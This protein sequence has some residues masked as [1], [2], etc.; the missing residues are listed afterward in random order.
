MSTANACPERTC[1]Q[2]LLAGQLGEADQEETIRHVEACAACQ[3]V[4]DS[5]TPASQS[6][7]DVALQLQ[8]ENPAPAPELR[9]VIEQAK[10]S[11]STGKAAGREDPDKTEAQEQ[12]TPHG[13]VSSG[14]ETQAEQRSAS[15]DDDLAF[16]GPSTKPDAIGRLGHYEILEVIGKGGFGVVLKGF[17]EK[18]HRIVAIKVLSPAYA[19]NGAARKRFIREAQTAA[20]VKNEHVVAIYSVQDEAQPPYL[21]MELI[22]GISLQDKLDKKGPLSLREILRIGLQTAEGLAAA[23]KQ[24]LVHRDIKP[25]NILLENGVERVKITD[26]GLARAVDDA[27]VTQSGTVAGTPM[28]MSPEQA[29]AMPIDHRSDLFSLGTVLYSICTGHPPF[30]ASGTHAVL[31]RVI[32]ASPRPIRELNP[33]IPDWLEAII[34]KLHAK[35]PEDRFQTAREVAEL[36]G[37]RLADVQAGRG[38]QGEPRRVSDRVAAPANEIREPKSTIASRIG[39]F[40]YGVLLLAVF[41][42]ILYL[43]FI[44]LFGYDS[45]ARTMFLV[46]SGLFAGLAFVVWCVSVLLRRFALRGWARRLYRTAIFCGVLAL[47]SGLGWVWMLVAPPSYA[48]TLE[49]DDPDTIVRIWPTA[50]TEPP[51][52]MAG[53]FEILGKPAHVIP[54]LSTTEIFLP[55]GHYWLKAEL[56]GQEVH[57]AFMEIKANHFHWQTFKKVGTETTSSR[58]GSSGMRS[59]VVPI[60]GLAILVELEKYKLRGVWRAVAGERDGKSLPKDLVDQVNLQLHFTADHVTVQMQ[61]TAETKRIDKQGAY[62]LN[63][64]QKPAHLDLI[65]A[66]DGKTMFAIYRLEGDSLHICGS[67]RTPQ[68]FHDQARFRTHALRPAARRRRQD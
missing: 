29:E 40:A 67:A 30:R 25:A 17:D 16:L 20:A 65:D 22:D 14:P 44:M 68:R 4:L 32:D 50:Q 62:K 43:L 64:R 3:H 54:N 36:L 13:D 35:K 2:A 66:F 6:W 15:R 31:K 33:E 12:S 53:A 27:S 39:A 5:L 61:E 48:V 11:G 8:K 51:D 59:R 56:D 38:V 42:A 23:H 46:G 45:G 52:H 1:L 28:Y 26:F 41:A 9:Q 37:A 49:M 10:A 57:R 24:G 47:G 55:A 18:L 21:V 19:A 58:H 34:A 63:P 60:P 7:E